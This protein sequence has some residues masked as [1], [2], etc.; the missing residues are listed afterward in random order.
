[1]PLVMQDFAQTRLTNPNNAVKLLVWPINSGMNAVPKVLNGFNQAIKPM[2]AGEYVTAVEKAT[3][4]MYH[5][6]CANNL[7]GEELAQRCSRLEKEGVKTICLPCSGKVDLLYL[8]KAFETGADGVVVVACREKECCNLEGNLRT[9]KRAQA[10]DLLL[11]EAGMGQGR[12]V[13]IQMEKNGVDQ[14]IR[15][16]EDFHKKIRSMS[17]PGRERRLM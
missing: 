10:V 6:Y 4:K 2:I 1:M 9:R 15:Q 7:E 12:I 11:A 3:L 14:A 5:F 8:L 16:V 13:V 17:S